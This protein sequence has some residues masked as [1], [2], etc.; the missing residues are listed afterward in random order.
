MKLPNI[1][2][3]LIGLTTIGC[4]SNPPE[5]VNESPAVTK[6]KENPP[7]PDDGEMPEENPLPQID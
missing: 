2:I 5:S 4:G 7:F 3:V 1:V 6:P